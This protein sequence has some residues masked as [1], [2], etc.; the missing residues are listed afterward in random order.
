MQPATVT[1]ISRLSAHRA[2]VRRVRHSLLVDS[3]SPQRGRPRP[4]VGPYGRV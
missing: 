1:E 2:T 3:R 4:Y